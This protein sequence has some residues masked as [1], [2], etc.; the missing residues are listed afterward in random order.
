MELIKVLEVKETFKITICSSCSGT[1]IVI[2][3]SWGSGASDTV[4][5]DECEGEGRVHKIEALCEVS[6]PFNFNPNME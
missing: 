4:A 1:G 3:D 2:D 5:C 6:V